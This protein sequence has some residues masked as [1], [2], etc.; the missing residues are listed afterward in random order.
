[1]DIDADGHRDILSGSYSRKEDE[2][3]G[4]FQVLRGK[5]DRTFRRAEVVKGTDGEPLIIPPESEYRNETISTRPFAV[6]WDG[7][8]H[9]DLVVGN[10]T[11][12]FYWFKGHGKGRF[13]PRPERLMAGDSPLRIKGGESD[14]FVIDWDGDGDLDLLTGSSRGG[15]Q[16]AENRAG[17]CRAPELGPLR[18]LIEPGPPIEDTDP[19][20]EAGLSGPTQDMRVWVDDVNSDGKLDLLV[21]GRVTAI[22]PAKG[23]SN[24]EFQKKFAAWRAAL[25]A[26]TE[27][28]RAAEALGSVAA[29][30]RAQNKARGD[31]NR[32]H[33]RRTL[34]MREELLGFVWLY[35]RK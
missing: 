3:A 31:L 4:L 2:M 32:V 10:Y 5:A 1:V 18:T 24:E 15:V 11:G 34:F 33:G 13:S 30:A 6:D 12:S 23:L 16:W 17:K 28:I 25:R 29:R 9:L 8:G 35:V 21:G 7:D 20:A 27:A 14:P 19:L 22:T 26:A